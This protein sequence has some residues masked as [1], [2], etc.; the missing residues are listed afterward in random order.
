[1]MSTRI[2]TMMGALSETQQRPIRRHRG[3]VQ[4]HG[5]NIFTI[6]LDDLRKMKRDCGTERSAAL[7]DCAE[8]DIDGRLKVEGRA[9]GQQRIDRERAQVEKAKPAGQVVDLMAALKASLA[10]EKPPQRER[11]ELDEALSP[12]AAPI[13]PDDPKRA[14]PISSL[15]P[16]QRV[17][18]L[19]SFDGIAGTEVTLVRIGIGSA[20]VRLSGSRRSM[21]V[22][23]PGMEQESKT[24]EFDAPGRLVSW[25]LGTMVI[26]LD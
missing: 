20:S 24:V 3:Y 1:M 9:R 25:A 22:R 21:T 6:P 11:D 5:W 8:A 23:E 13:I 4:K 19:N 12:K 7:L 18:T 26:P 15:T 14:V 17:R 2:D 16:G 10:Q